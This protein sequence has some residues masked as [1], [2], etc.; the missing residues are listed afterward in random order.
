VSRVA[1]FT[2]GHFHEVLDDAVVD[3]AR[4]RRV[5][6]CS[7]KVYYDLLDKRP[8]DVAIV[9]LEQIAPFPTEAIQKVLARYRRVK[10]WAWVQEESQNMG[11]WTFVDPL[12]RALGCPIEYVGRDASASPA[13]GSLRVHQREQKELVEAAIG[14]ALPHLVR[15]LPD[16]KPPP[17]T[18]AGERPALASR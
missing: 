13:T 14:G 4:T 2:S 15:T 17:P 9:R 8:E 18:P 10:E 11:A 1:D 16:M 7:G 6:F 3:P 5:L 12:F